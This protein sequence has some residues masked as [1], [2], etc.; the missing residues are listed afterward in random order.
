MIKAFF[1]EPIALKVNEFLARVS[2]YILGRLQSVL[3]LCY[4]QI[5]KIENDVFEAVENGVE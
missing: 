1:E 5:P 3:P 4:S 2:F